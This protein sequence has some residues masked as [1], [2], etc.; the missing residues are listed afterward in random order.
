M[1]HSPC[2][3]CPAW[4]CCPRAHACGILG[5]GGHTWLCCSSSPF[6]SP[7]SQEFPRSV[8]GA[9]IRASEAA[10][11]TQTPPRPPFHTPLF[12]WFLGSSLL[13]RIWVI[14]DSPEPLWGG[15]FSACGGSAVGGMSTLQVGQ[16][17]SLQAFGAS[18]GPA[19]SPFIWVLCLCILSTRWRSFSELQKPVSPFCCVQQLAA[20]I[21]HIRG[22]Y[23]SCHTGNAFL[24][25]LLRPCSDFFQSCFLSARCVWWCYQ[26]CSDPWGQRAGSCNNSQ[27]NSETLQ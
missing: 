21:K 7:I 26:L 19:S 27:S 17:L 1:F 12:G 2:L 13:P 9:S 4:R 10:S 24:R 20:V 25:S 15:V 11:F 14:T 6:L 22:H 23:S 3:P 8:C 16:L 5:C 18:A